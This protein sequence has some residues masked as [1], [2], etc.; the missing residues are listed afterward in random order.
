MVS[1]LPSVA[2]SAEG[3]ESER[4]SGVSLGRVGS[5]LCGAT[6][7]T[8]PVSSL[9]LSVVLCL[10]LACPLHATQSQ[11]ARQTL[12]SSPSQPTDSNVG[13]LSPS[14]S[15]QRVVRD[16]NNPTGRPPRLAGLESEQEPLG[17]EME[18]AEK[19][20]GEKGEKKGKGEKEEAE[21]PSRIEL[22]ISGEETPKKT[23]DP[24]DRLKQY[25]YDVFQKAGRS[26][27]PVLD[28]PV[29]PDYVIGPGDAF[30]INVWGRV[31][32]RATVVVDRSGQIVLPE[33]GVLKVWGMKFANLESYLHSEMS[34]KF[35]DFRLSVSMDRL[36]TIQVFV[37]GEAEAP[38]AYTVSSLCTVINALSAAGG[39]S[40][41]GSLRKI[42]LTRSQGDPNEIDLYAF[43]QAGDRRGDVRLQDGDTIHI[44]LIGPVVAVGGNVKRPAIYEM[45]KPIN[46]REALDLAGGVTFAGWLQRIQVERVE[47]HHRRIVADL[48]LSDQADPAEQNRVMAMTIQDGDLIKVL[49]IDDRR[50]NVV[51][52]EG[53]VVQ[54]GLYE[55]KPG[56][57][58]RD[59][60]S[61][62][63]VMKLQP[64]LSD[65]EIIRL[66]PP[67]LHP[68]RVQF[69]LGKLM[70]GN[71]SENIEL[72]QYDT[73]HVF[74]WDER[75]VET[76]RVS[77]MVYEPNE[78]Q[79]TPGMRVRDLISRAGGLQKNVYLNKAEITR[80]HI[81][82]AG[83]TTERINVDLTRVMAG[84]PQQ[85]I[86]LQ[87][88]DYL[89]IR[90]I[91]DLEFNLTATINGEVRFP[92]EY[93]I[94]RDETLS[95]L[96]E[97]AGGYTDKAYLKGAVF[98]RESAKVVQ[99]RRM[100][101]MVSRLEESMLSDAGQKIS[102]AI[103]AETAKSQEDALGAKK[104]LITKLRAA[105]IDGRVVIRVSPLD[106]LKGSKDD[107]RLED[108]DELTIP[109]T[110]GVV[111][112][113]GEVF[114]QT[115]LVYEDGATVSYYLRKVG[116]M[117]KDA[118]DKEVS[119]VKA[120]GSVTSRQQDSF[121]QMISW[122]KQSN[123]W[124]F[125]G[126]MSM[127]LNPGD[128]I[129]VPKKLD[130]FF[131]LQTT[132]DVTQI[133]MQIA[134]TVGIAFAI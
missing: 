23:R 128:T 51:T 18:N 25:G 43:L 115:P 44:P 90:P 31:D 38:G 109:Q 113:V 11:G 110:P 129:V 20:E 103:S 32:N 28:V 42:R 22:L 55:W 101:Q 26:F 67:D 118:D 29:G 93:P 73:I 117:T 34:R 37:V 87:D 126:F 114:N 16:V 95:S 92:G 127:P 89:V 112:V 125:G 52:L 24:S 46:L 65:G 108:K 15:G 49:S 62:Y 30:T 99:R 104:E 7:V 3:R 39:A 45:N 56:M 88:Y 123:R 131:W 106:E 58:L 94:R 47:N 91:P 74:K 124:V 120:D 35:S 27:S 10:L 82:Q 17:S 116:G 64:N 53:H 133:M 2:Q 80:S 79:L 97:R 132:K 71:K 85:D 107:V 119:V 76:V 75:H 9:V 14:R 19:K 130:R 96:I 111:Y 78:Y 41:N 69:N 86:L 59:V 21:K 5:S 48:N 60:L 40:K 68:T 33:V 98:T 4:A 36:R 66:V 122:D 134:V 102:G 12:G 83:M 13:K 57:K 121:G 84:D 61:S 72:A 70:S 1:G 105:E 63:D 50:E 6:S 77:G 8:R 100:D 81:T 54:P